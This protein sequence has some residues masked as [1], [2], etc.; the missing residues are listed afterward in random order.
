MS[1]KQT[2]PDKGPKIKIEAVALTLKTAAK[3]F[4][5]KRLGASSQPHC[6]KK[7][8]NIMIKAATST[9]NYYRDNDPLALPPKKRPLLPL[10]LLPKKRPHLDVNED[11]Q[12]RLI[13]KK[14]GASHSKCRPLDKGIKTEVKKKAKNSGKRGVI[15]GPN[16]APPM[17][18]NL[19]ELVRR[20]FDV[21]TVT[22]VIQKSLFHTDLEKV[23]NRLSMTLKQIASDEFLT[24]EEKRTLTR[25]RPD[26]RLKGI[27]VD[28]IEPNMSR[29]EMMLKKWELQSSS[30]YVLSHNWHNVSQRN[31]L[32]AG[33]IVQ[34][35]FFRSREGKP[36]IALVNLG[37]ELASPSS[38][39][40][41]KD[42]HQRG[43]SE[44]RSDVTYL[45]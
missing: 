7:E 10:A 42:A 27:K 43:D 9:I 28:F 6:I 13:S 3:P 45:D 32:K 31:K 39:A 21:S 26:K 5:T 20:D 18:K 8:E 25:R 23:E 1:Q 15:A 16:P 33:D 40:V 19:M 36:C 17:P 4:P 35:W 22:F 12:K 11:D 14:S 30:S 37:R 34:I 38:S 29:T 41:G 2:F 24:E 44:P